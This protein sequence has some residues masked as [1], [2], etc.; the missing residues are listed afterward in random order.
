MNG[1]IFERWVRQFKSDKAN[2][3]MKVLLLDNVS[4]HR[5]TIDLSNV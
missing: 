5:H 1:G 4:S 2:E 3:V